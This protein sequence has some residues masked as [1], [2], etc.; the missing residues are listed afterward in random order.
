MHDDSRQVFSLCT[1]YASERKT[2]LEIS[3]WHRE[4]VCLS[5]ALQVQPISDKPV[6][7]Y[8]AS[9]VDHLV[10]AAPS[11]FFREPVAAYVKRLSSLK[12]SQNMCETLS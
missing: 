2:N 8:I 12:K 11:C 10:A 7:R 1:G 5:V 9:C 4:K 6:V 3:N